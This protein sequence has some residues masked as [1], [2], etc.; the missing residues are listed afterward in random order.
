MNK[1]DYREQAGFLKGNGVY[2]LSEQTVSDFMKQLDDTIYKVTQDGDYY[3][4]VITEHYN[5]VVVL[6]KD[7]MG[8]GDKKLG[9]VL[10]K[11][12]LATLRDCSMK[13]EKILFYNEA[14]KIS[15]DDD[16]VTILRELQESGVDLILCG[17]CIKFFE[18]DP[19][20]GEVSNMFS[21]LGIQMNANQV[22][23]P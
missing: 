21:I 17:T 9:R 15:S 13:P 3:V 1:Y 14:V 6:D 12:Y 4:E 11:S 10:L 18:I 22:L 2:I 19:Q 16:F 5:K 23:K 7:Y 8:E 20:V